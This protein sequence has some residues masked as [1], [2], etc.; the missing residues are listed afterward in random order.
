MRKSG[1]P[2]FGWQIR[3][4]FDYTMNGRSHV[5]PSGQDRNYIISDVGAFQETLAVEIAHVNEPV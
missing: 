2:L 3:D 5:W 1:V 4:P